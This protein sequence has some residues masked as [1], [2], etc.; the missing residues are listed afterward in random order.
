MAD[1]IKVESEGSGSSIFLSDPIDALAF[2]A[3]GLPRKDCAKRT[4]T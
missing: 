4:A 3:R 1:G 2:S